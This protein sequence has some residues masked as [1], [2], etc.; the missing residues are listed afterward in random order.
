MEDYGLSINFLED[1]TTKLETI[2][3]NKNYQFKVKLFKKNLRNL[4]KA[5][6]QLPESSYK[7]YAQQIVVALEAPLLKDNFMTFEKPQYEAIRYCLNT[8][9]KKELDDKF[10][11]DCIDKML[12]ANLDITLP[13]HGVKYL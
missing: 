4:F 3:K 13:L 10:V 5:S 2:P 6:K 8:L 12:E 1:I 11:E 7:D 9:R